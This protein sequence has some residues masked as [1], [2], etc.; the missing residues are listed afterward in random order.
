ML[1]NKDVI[2]FANL[3]LRGFLLGVSCTEIV[4]STSIAAAAGEKNTLSILRR[5]SRNVFG[6]AL[7]CFGGE[8]SSADGEPP[9][10][11]TMRLPS[12]KYLVPYV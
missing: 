2:S 6:C 10:T 1:L 4:S 9:S 5:R 12:P 3:F 7:L 11:A 8:V